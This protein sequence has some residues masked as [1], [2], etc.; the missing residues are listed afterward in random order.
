MVSKSEP[1]HV[2]EVC[3]SRRAGIP[4]IKPFTH[5]HWL[6]AAALFTCVVVLGASRMAPGVSGV[7]HDDGIYVATGKAIAEGNG[8]HLVNL[9]GEPPQTK[10]PFL[11]PVVLSIF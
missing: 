3:S 5:R 8:Y 4:M 2:H 1:A 7:Y 6:V 9:P 10:Y 11:Y